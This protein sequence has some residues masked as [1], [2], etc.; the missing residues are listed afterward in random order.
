M[1]KAAVFDF[2][3]LLTRCV[4]S[5]VSKMTNFTEQTLAGGSRRA[6]FWF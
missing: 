2:A 5:A 3:I 6:Y 4:V 1:I